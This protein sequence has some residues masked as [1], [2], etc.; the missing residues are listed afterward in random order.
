MPQVKEGRSSA[1]D[2]NQILEAGMQAQTLLQSQVF[3]AAYRETLNHYFN[4]WLS[5][6]VDHS[7][8]R[9]E[10]YFRLRGL[11]DAAQTLAGFVAQAETIIQQQSNENEFRPQEY[12]Q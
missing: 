1:T 2:I 9:E 11:Q 12:Q 6:Q 4:E 5:T 8:K 3:G 10:I 7:K